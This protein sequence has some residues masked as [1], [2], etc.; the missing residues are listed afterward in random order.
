MSA[1]ASHVTPWNDRA[2]RLGNALLGLSTGDRVAIPAHNR[3][4][5]V[6]ICLAA[7]KAGLVAV[8][9][10]FRLTAPEV[11]FIISDCGAAA[12]MRRVLRHDVPDPAKSVP[13]ESE[14]GRT[15]R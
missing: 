11:A 6:E 8:P 7:A 15:T 1:A 14:N 12:M 4:E 10:N 2:C 5:W 9:I 3:L 13:C